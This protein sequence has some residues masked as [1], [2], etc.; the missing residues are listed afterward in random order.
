MIEPALST[1]GE[2]AALEEDPVVRAHRRAAQ[3]TLRQAELVALL[4]TVLA[5]AL[6]AYL[7][8]LARG[9]LSDPDRYINTFTVSLFALA[10]AV[11][12]LLHLTELFK[13]RSLYYQELVHYPSTRVHLLQRKIDRLERD[14]AHLVKA[15]ATKEELRTLRTGVDGPLTQLTKAVRRYERKEETLRLTAEERFA[16]LDAKLEEALQDSLTMAEVVERLKREHAEA[17]SPLQT[18]LRVINHLVGQSSAGGSYD[19][20]GSRTVHWY[21]RGPLWYLF[22]PVSISSLAVEWIASKGLASSPSSG[23]EAARP[24]RVAFE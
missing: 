10:T 5:P 8:Y 13:R 3:H 11:K 18:L 23:F 16:L 19:K 20:K 1:A 9:M 17:A 2:D 4:M 6:G 21:E 24:A 22:L 7:L 14:V 15:F 12:P